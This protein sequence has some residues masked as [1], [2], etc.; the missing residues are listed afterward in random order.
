MPFTISFQ[1]PLWLLL[2]ALVPVIWLLSRR[3]MGA[4]GG[5]RAFLA[6][7][8]RSLVLVGV[9]MALASPQWNR[10]SENVS[11]A[12]LLDQ[13]ES[14]PA[15]YRGEMLRFVTNNVERHRQEA[16]G[17]RAA[18]IVFG[19]EAAVE[20]PPVEFAPGGRNIETLVDPTATNLADSLAK[21]AALLPNT[22]ARRVVLVTDGN[23]N[24]GTAAR[25]SQ[26]LKQAGIGVDVVPTPT[27]GKQDVAVESVAAPSAAKKDQ[28]LE[29]RVVLNN[30]GDDPVPTA[31]KLR[32]VRK[33]GGRE[34]TITEESLTL[35]VGKSVFTFRE[36][37]TEADFYVYEARF[38]PDKTGE[39]RFLA[40]NVA[41]GFTDVRGKGRV[42]LLEDYQFP[43]EFDALVKSLRNEGVETDVVTSDRAFS[44]LAE[45]QRY[46]SVI[47][48]NVPRVAGDAAG[49]FV[50]LSDEQIGMLVRN[51]KELGCGLVMIGGQRSFGAGG[52][53]GS[54]LEK[55][56]PV[57]FQIKNA[58]VI[59]VGALALVIDK[60]GSMSGEK[61]NLSLVAAREAIKMMGPR[62]F[63][64]VVAFDE[65]PYNVVPLERVGNG[66]NALARVSRIT[67]GGGTDLYPGMKMGYQSLKQADAA[68]KHMIVLTDGMTPEAEFTEL[69]RQMQKDK[70]T[71]SAV[72]V[73]G[74]ADRA[75]LARIASVG[76]GKFYAAPNPRAVPRI[77]MVEARRIA[78]P[79][80][81]EL[82]PPVAP[83]R[84]ADHQMLTGIE[85][86]FPPLAGFVQTTVKENSLVEV[87]LRSPVPAIEKNA[88][89]LATWTYG[90]GKAAVLTT[91][92]GS[93]WA[94]S[95]KSWDNYEKF[96]SQLVRWSM[97]PAGEQ[98]NF[99][100]ATQTTDGRTQV[101]IDALDDQ[102]EFVNQL[103]LYGSVVGP[104]LK[105]LPLT[106]EQAGPGRYVGE[107]AS[108]DPG[109]YFV[110]IS[111]PAGS[112]LRAGVNVGA[113]R[114]YGDFQ[115][116]LPLL[117]RL[118]GNTPEG[119]EPGQVVATNGELPFATEAGSK[120]AQDLD[121]FRRDLPPA[122]T[123]RDMWPPLVVAACVV[124]FSDIFIRRV[125]LDFTGLG[126]WLSSL[127]TRRQ[128]VE[129]PAT[130]ARLSAKKAEI[131][132][133][134]QPPAVE[135]PPVAIARTVQ[136]VVAA[137]PQAAETPQE[138]PAE[139]TM[140]SRLLAAKK[141][142][143]D[144]RWR[145][146]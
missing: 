77:F 144:N 11:V 32:I 58:K 122:I 51:T 103:S 54:E 108:S 117:E 37:P 115:V 3:S 6:N 25:Q 82:S 91:D 116:N 56:M 127:L 7:T 27:G 138:K 92:A 30:Q 134:Y 118:A 79:V 42:L 41:T 28:P 137:K 101:V 19:R 29:V 81:R 70:I 89:V 1:E 124:F 121:P 18:V 50:S 132:E 47:L 140:T 143:K 145:K 57:D 14:I 87:L 22:S 93:L 86:A 40:N 34:E 64:N 8:L 146:D 112:M 44:S 62:D 63:I 123:S 15:E 107:F 105:P 36:T 73:G 21:A 78:T 33:A 9:I 111:T 68:V 5:W 31:G 12:Y 114:E 83:Q 20:V 120:L 48:A 16:K 46:D 110:T 90:L 102:E 45:L 55:A 141:A 72:A 80:I 128:L 136:E 125:Q 69:C 135:A 98:G 65:M 133:R 4:L 17:D 94:G 96:F 97:R 126:A 24:L 35:P 106:V 59:P 71:V 2:L 52:W 43:G 119:G 60:S 85:G 139:E 10:F 26:Q 53:A 13:S 104:G 49:S 131:R 109:S 95:W 74:D 39:D 67:I 113:S 38:I 130:L 99:T 100:I 61:L 23:E 84:I 66:R 88:T 142:V 129:A 76:K 75:L